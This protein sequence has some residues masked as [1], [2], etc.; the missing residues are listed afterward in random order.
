LAYS[1]DKKLQSV[2][3]AVVFNLLS[4]DIYYA[5]KDSGSFVNEKRLDLTKKTGKSTKDMVVG[6]N[7]S[8]L[9]ENLFISISKLISSVNHIRHLGANALEMCY[10]AQGSIDAYLDFRNKIRAIDMAACYLI[11]KEAG[12]LVFDEKGND[13]NCDLSTD[14]KM[15]FIAVSNYETYGWISNLIKNNR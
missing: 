7:I 1:S 9:P 12:G 14:S 13:L 11:A 2:T 3:D 15:S 6:L 8:G 10:F 4:R 5:T